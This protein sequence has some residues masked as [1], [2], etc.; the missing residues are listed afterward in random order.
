M[1]VGRS[2]CSCASTDSGEFDRAG[3]TNG[4]QHSVTGVATTGGIR[5]RH[6]A[7]PDLLKIL[8]PDQSDEFLLTLPDRHFRDLYSERATVVIHLPRGRGGRDVFW[9][10]GWRPNRF[11]GGHLG[12]DPRRASVHTRLAIA[13]RFLDE[14][15]GYSSDSHSGWEGSAPPS[16]AGWRTRRAS[17]TSTIG[18]I[19]RSRRPTRDNS[20]LRFPSSK[21]ALR[22]PSRHADR[23]RGRRH[24]ARAGA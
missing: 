6:P 4:R 17:R 2:D 7:V 15:L 20:P 13:Q 9:W 5:H 18:V 12:V 23:A 10:A 14:W 24:R 1:P 3:G 8:L 19:P 11:Q 16:W 21:R 22:R